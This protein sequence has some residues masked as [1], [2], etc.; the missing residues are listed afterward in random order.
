MDINFE[1]QDLYRFVCEEWDQ[2]FF[3]YQTDGSWNVYQMSCDGFEQMN[4]CSFAS[5]NLAI[6]YTTDQI[7]EWDKM[8]KESGV[9]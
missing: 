7:Q 2:E 3:I 5:P 1:R 9:G 6:K 8:N 4:S